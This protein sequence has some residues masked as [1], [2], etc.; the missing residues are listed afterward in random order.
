MTYNDILNRM[1]VLGDALQLRLPA[2][3]MA[4]TLMLRAHYAKGMKEWQTMCEQIQKD[5][6]R[7]EGESDEDYLKRVNDVLIPKAAD[8]AELP[9]R[10]YTVEAFEQLCGA[11]AEQGEME[12]SVHLTKDG[13]RAQ[14]PAWLWLDHMVVDLVTQD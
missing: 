10:R 6:P 2:K 3:A 5:L 8:E 12:S 1:S 9:E 14:V 11:A 7:S 4:E 13:K